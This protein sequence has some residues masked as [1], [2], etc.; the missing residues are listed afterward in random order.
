MSRNGEPTHQP[1]TLINV[2]EI[3]ADQVDTSIARWRQRATFMATQPGF[4]DARL[5]R[6]LTKQARFQLV[7]IAHWESHQAL[8]DANAITDTEFQQHIQAATAATAITAN[9]ATYQVVAE[10][11]GPAQRSARPTP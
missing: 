5:H 3:L 7:N 10:F 4:L 1:V 9:P 6:A 11:P 8:H 2:F